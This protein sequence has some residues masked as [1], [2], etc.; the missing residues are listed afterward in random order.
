MKITKDK[1]IGYVIIQMNHSENTDQ[2]SYLFCDKIEYLHNRG[3]HKE[4]GKTFDHHLM[5]YRKKDR[6]I[7]K[8]WLKNDTKD[9][10]YKNIREALKS[11]GLEILE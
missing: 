4:F 3:F 5:F 6:L 10:E 8:V 1:I 7:F 2:P 11:V 9:K